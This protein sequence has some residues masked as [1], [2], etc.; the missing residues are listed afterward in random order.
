MAL[1]AEKVRRD[2]IKQDI[3]KEFLRASLGE[4]FSFTKN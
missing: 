2:K 4:I 1:R 3:E